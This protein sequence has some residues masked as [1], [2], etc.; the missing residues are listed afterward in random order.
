MRQFGDQFFGFW[1]GMV[2]VKSLPVFQVR[3]HGHQLKSWRQQGV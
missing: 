1:F 3:L 2:W